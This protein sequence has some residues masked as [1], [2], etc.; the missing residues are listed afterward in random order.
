MTDARSYTRPGYTTV[1]PSLTVQDAARALDFYPSAFGATELYRLTNPDASIAHAELRFGD[2][3][4]SVSEESPAW[5]NVS[6]QTLG[7]TPV[8]LNLYVPAADAAVTQ[9]VTAGAT[10]VHPVE[11]HF[12]GDRSGR[13]QDPFGHVWIVSAFVEDVPPD[14]VQRR[15]DRMMQQTS[16]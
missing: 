4:V 9:A 5:G 11:S 10:L 2:T 16:G 1:A 6:P 13:V 14:E 15:L 7:G 8:V 3:I 12:Y